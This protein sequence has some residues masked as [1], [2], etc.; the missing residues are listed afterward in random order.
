[1]TTHPFSYESMTTPIYFPMT[2]VT[3]FTMTLFISIFPILLFWSFLWQIFLLFSNNSWYVPFTM[4]TDMT[5]FIWQLLYPFLTTADMPLF[6]W[7]FIPFPTTADMPLFIWQLIP[8]P[9]TADM[10]LFIWQLIPYPTTAEMPHFIWQLLYP[11]SYNSLHVLFDMTG[12]ANI[13]WKLVHIKMNGHWWQLVPL[14]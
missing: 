8:F 9:I 14:Q 5:H 12:H 7:Q 11:L 2:A 10:L 13:C 6:I 4:T 1:M 3:C